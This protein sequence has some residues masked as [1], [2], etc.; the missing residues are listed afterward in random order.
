M[1]T[2][3][4][5]KAEKMLNDRQAIV[6][7]SAQIHITPALTEVARIMSEIRMT[8]KV[9]EFTGRWNGSRWEFRKCEPPTIA[10]E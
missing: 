1:N 2:H 8:G 10:E 7:V 3:D 5:S 6:P 9:G 4:K